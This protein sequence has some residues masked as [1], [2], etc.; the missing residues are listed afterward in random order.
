MKFK[1]QLLYRVTLSCV[2]FWN[3][4][5]VMIR[6]VHT[7]LLKG[8]GSGSLLAC[9]SKNIV[10]LIGPYRY[11]L[12]KVCKVYADCGRFLYI[13]CVFGNFVLDYDLFAQH[14]VYV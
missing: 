8:I 4:I 12:F 13:S 10:L 3:H 6:L 14:K 7:K 11:M 1:Y 2:L 5:V 9:L